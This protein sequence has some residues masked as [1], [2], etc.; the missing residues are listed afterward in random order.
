MTYSVHQRQTQFSKLLDQA[1]QGE[2]VLIVRRGHPTARLVIEWNSTDKPVL[3]GMRGEI[4]YTPGWDKAMTDQEA[5][6][7][8]EG[9]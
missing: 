1:E 6:D 9:K 5:H 3:G 4:T 2:E 8:L 7:F